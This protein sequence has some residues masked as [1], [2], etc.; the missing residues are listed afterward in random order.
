MLIYGHLELR[1]MKLLKVKL[2]SGKGLDCNVNIK[3]HCKVKLAKHTGYQNLK[4]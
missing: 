4:D 2:R 3:L 1:I